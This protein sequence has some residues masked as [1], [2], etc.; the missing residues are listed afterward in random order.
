MPKNIQPKRHREYKLEI[1]AFSPTTIP[2][3]RL[4]EYLSDL[5]T[6]LGSPSNVHLL[7]ID[8][9]ST[10][11]VVLVDFEAEPKVRDRIKAVKNQEAPEDALIAAKNIDRRLLLD[12]AKAE[13]VDPVGAKVF[14]FPGRENA[15][16]QEF[17]PVNQPGSFQGIPI[18]V[19]GENDPVPLHLED[20][21][22]KYIVW[23]RRS[24]AKEIAKYLFTTVLRVD[25]TGRWI[26]QRNGEWE[27]L[28]FTATSYT[29]IEDSTLTQDI[30]ALRKVPGEWKN[31]DDPLGE[32][33]RIRHGSN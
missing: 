33:E 28:S 5:A 26:R 4:A 29:P 23:V 11:P 8:K 16:R 3:A 21:R 13:I 10:V 18:K 27:M 12:N 20:G 30:A 15:V 7:R 31:L 25:G 24:L 2:M 19:G 17:G 32:L 9:G 1:D 14:R 22:E 6:L